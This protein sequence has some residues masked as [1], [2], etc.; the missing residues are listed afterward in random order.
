MLQNKHKYYN[1]W[2]YTTTIHKQNIKISKQ[3][4]VE[5][6]VSMQCLDSLLLVLLLNLEQLKYYNWQAYAVMF[7]VNEWISNVDESGYRFEVCF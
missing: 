2:G 6:Q 5:K 3:C 1:R 4:W 7:V